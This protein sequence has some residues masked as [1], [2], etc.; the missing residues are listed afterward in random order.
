MKTTLIREWKE[1]IWCWCALKKFPYGFITLRRARSDFN[2]KK[3]GDETFFSQYKQDM[4]LRYFLFPNKNNG[5]F[6]DI[7]GNNPIMINNTYY[8]ENIG[9]N[10]LAFEPVKR[11][12]ELWKENRTTKCLQIALGGEKEAEME[13]V[14]YEDDVMS[15][16]K[17]KVDFEGEIKNTYKVKVRPLKNVLKEYDIRQV[18]FMSLDVEGGE[19]EVLKGID[20]DEVDIYSILIENNKGT[21]K[22]KAIRKFLIKQGYYFYGRLWLD[23]L[24]VKR[25]YK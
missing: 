1:R 12:S 9:W 24:W 25:D 11:N 2:E 18:D 22:A 13:F 5:F 23:D 19:I 3:V 20:F 17:G 14:E 8:F 6:L 7:G 4:F 16:I 21:E 15:G 10:G